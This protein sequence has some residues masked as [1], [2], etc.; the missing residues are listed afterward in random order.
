MT[1]TKQEIQNVIVDMRQEIN[2]ICDRLLRGAEMP[3]RVYDFDSTL[4]S[5]LFAL[6][7]I[8]AAVEGL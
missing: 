7:E 3:D 6:K 1:L 4:Q 2:E 5:A 8:N